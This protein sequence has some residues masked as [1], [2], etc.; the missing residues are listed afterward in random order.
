MFDNVKVPPLRS[1]TPSFPAEASAYRERGRRA[2]RLSL[3]VR[4]SCRARSSG[5]LQPRKL[6]R[7]LERCCRP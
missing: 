3:V 6:L 4:A 7:H 1:A 2:A 5:F